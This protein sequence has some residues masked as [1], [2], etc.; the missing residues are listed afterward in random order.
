MLLPFLFFRS[1]F[2]SRFCVVF[3]SKFSSVPLLLNCVIVNFSELNLQWIKSFSFAWE[4]YKHKRE[5]ENE[6]ERINAWTKKINSFFW[7]LLNENIHH[8]RHTLWMLR[9]LCDEPALMEKEFV[10]RLK[11]KQV[12]FYRKLN[13]NRKRSHEQSQVIFFTGIQWENHACVC[14]TT[15]CACLSLYRFIDGAARNMHSN[16]SLSETASEW[17]FLCSRNVLQ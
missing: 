6:T 4:K 3:S 14:V 7:W 12:F 15:V 8:A 16:T 9:K 1:L 10:N 17:F 13:R 2:F 5:K 11:N